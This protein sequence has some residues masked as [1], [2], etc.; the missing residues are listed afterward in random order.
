MLAQQRLEA[1]LVER[2][3]A[4]GQRGELRLVDVDAEDL[5]AELGHAGGM[6]GTE[7]AGAEDG[8]AQ[9]HAGSPRKRERSERLVT[10]LM[11]AGYRARPFPAVRAAADTLD[12]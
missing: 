12:A 2:H 7:V 8:E 1:R 11:A 6:G 4:V 9:G 5:E 3:P 10:V